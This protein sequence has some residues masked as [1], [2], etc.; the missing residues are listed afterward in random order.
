MT[1]P[2]IILLFYSWGTQ[3]ELFEFTWIGLYALACFSDWF[4][5][6]IARNWSSQQSDFGK[7]I[8]PL[9]D[10]VLVI[11]IIL[12]IFSLDK[13][14]LF[15]LACI[16]IVVLR[17][18]LVTVVRKPFIGDVNALAVSQIGRVKAGF[19]MAAFGVILGRDSLFSAYFDRFVPHFAFEDFGF[20]LLVTATVL[21]VWS[22]IGYFMTWVNT[23]GK[24]TA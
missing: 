4:D 20:L 22:G 6:Y 8:D 19:Q 24:T 9:A 3:T 14:G 23:Q 10:K 2:A 17:E 21:T 1:G 12:L 13:V 7:I 16:A 15:E 11:S 5:G 18:V